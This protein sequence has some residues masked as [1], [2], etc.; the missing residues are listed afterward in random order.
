MG[1]AAVSAAMLAIIL[2]GIAVLQGGLNRQIAMKWGLIHAI[3]LNCA[4]IFLLSIILY[5]IVKIFPQLFPVSMR[6]RA[7]IGPYPGWIWWPGFFGLC[8]VAG[9]PMAI[10][11]GGA[12]QVFVGIVFGQMVVGLIWDLFQEGIP[13]SV[14]RI[15]GAVFVGIGLV[16][17]SLK[18]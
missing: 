12:L 14:L 4:V 5:F 7:L 17:V 9:I 11:K 6:A 8:L 16:L 13:V 18:S 2:G 15:T 3:V 10:A 1:W